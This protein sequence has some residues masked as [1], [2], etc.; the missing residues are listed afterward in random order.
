MK[1]IRKIAVVTL[2]ASSGLLGCAA[3]QT[4][5]EHPELLQRIQAAERAAAEAQQAAARA[6]ARADEAAA[7][8]AANS[9]KVDRAFQKSQQK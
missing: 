3:Q 2:L 7:A 4:S 9:Q 8:A 6:Q 1:S 5:H